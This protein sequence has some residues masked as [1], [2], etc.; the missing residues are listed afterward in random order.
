MM[1]NTTLGNLCMGLNGCAFACGGLAWWITG[2]IWRFRADGAFASGDIAPEGTSLD[3]WD[4]TITADGSLY[5][6]RSGKFMLIY[7]FI[8]F[9]LMA[10][11]F[12]S[13]LT[14]ALWSCCAGKK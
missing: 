4:A 10:C 7:Y 6:H 9:G 13:S 12:L 3:D 14:A 8:C 1:L 11:C 5:Q 2:I